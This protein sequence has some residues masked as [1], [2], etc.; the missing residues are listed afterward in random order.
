MGRPS[1]STTAFG[2]RKHCTRMGK[3]FR[4][5]FQLILPLTLRSAMITLTETARQSIAQHAQ[6]SYPNECVGLLIGRIEG[7]Q[8]NVE[9]IHQAANNWNVEVGMTN[10]E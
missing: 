4:T 3:G 2:M 8:K 7:K 6:A 1:I 5:G 9:A 10:A